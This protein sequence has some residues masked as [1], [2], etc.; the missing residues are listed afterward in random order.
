M[1]TTYAYKI[2]Y[3]LNTKMKPVQKCNGITDLHILIN[4]E[5]HDRQIKLLYG[6]CVAVLYKLTREWT[7]SE[8]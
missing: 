2:E 6:H 5:I 7:R 1:N 8:L 4:I 3:I